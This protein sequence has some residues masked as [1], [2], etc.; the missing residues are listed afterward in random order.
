[1]A[2]FFRWN[3]NAASRSPTLDRGDSAL[4][5]KG[6]IYPSAAQARQQQSRFHVFFTSNGAIAQ[7]YPST[8]GVLVKGAN[9]V[10]LIYLGASRQK[11]TTRPSME[12]CREEDAWCAKLRML[13]PSWYRDLQDRDDAGN[14]VRPMT[15]LERAKV[16][17]GY[18]D[19]SNG[20]GIWVMRC[21]DRQRPEGWGRYELCLD[22]RE[23]CR[24][25]QELGATWYESASEVEELSELYDQKKKRESD[26]L[27]A[28]YGSFDT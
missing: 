3:N 22:M 15:M 18:G 27:E 1:M 21:K 17:V 6:P 8:G 24:A 10:D 23:R 20:G 9:T 4:L 19:E 16:F 14:D 11:P 7:G 2:R 13:A 28:E 12:A 25:M 26:E 5:S